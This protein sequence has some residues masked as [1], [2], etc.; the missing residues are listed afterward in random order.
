MESNLETSL[1][2]FT[3]RWLQQ[4]RVLADVEQALMLH[5]VLREHDA[6]SESIGPS[7]TRAS[8]NYV[9]SKDCGKMQK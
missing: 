4:T 1:W 8:P 5:C 2:H 3:S 6:E 7:A 9:A